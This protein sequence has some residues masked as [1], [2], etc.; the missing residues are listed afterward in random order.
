MIGCDK[1]TWQPF[2]SI[3]RMWTSW[4]FCSSV[5]TGEE[6]DG[7]NAF[8]TSSASA[9][10]CLLL[11]GR[12]V[13]CLMTWREWCA[14]DRR[15]I[16]TFY[17]GIGHVF[18]VRRGYAEDT[19]NTADIRYEYVKHTFAYAV[20]RCHYAMDTLWIRYGYV[21]S[22]TDVDFSDAIRWEVGRSWTLT[23]FELFFV[24]VGIRSGHTPWCDRPIRVGKWAGSFFNEKGHYST[25][26]VH[27][28]TLKTEPVHFSMAGR[29]S[30]LHRPCTNYTQTIQPRPFLPVPLHGQ[31][32]NRTGA[33]GV[34]SV[35]SLQLWSVKVQFLSPSASLTH[36]PIGNYCKA[37]FV[38]CHFS[39][40]RL[41]THSWNTSGWETG[42]TDCV[43]VVTT[44][45]FAW[46]RMSCRATQLGRTL[47]LLG[48]IAVFAVWTCA[49]RL[50]TFPATIR[51][52]IREQKGIEGSA[53]EDLL[54]HWCCAPCALC[55]E[56]QEV[57]T[58]NRKMVIERE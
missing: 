57:Q 47:K 18:V 35:S 9:P 29:N 48:R 49:F 33:G 7:S 19:S 42:K 37:D 46:W 6:G 10:G 16:Y 3:S 17:S 56:S 53:A 15:G 26:W 2:S 4:Q 38:K 34:E 24:Y 30:T 51:G 22:N 11:L 8:S 58:I 5:P 13:D 54:V 45:E 31:C 39:K 25:V 50:L 52:K 12:H 32:I 20:I 14:W 23:I 28:S 27:F 43:A 36:P 44:V 55:Q 1:S 41:A 21:H 40:E